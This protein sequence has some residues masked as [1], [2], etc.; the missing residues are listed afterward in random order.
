MDKLDWS[1]I[2]AFLAVA[3][4]GSLSA[5]ARQLGTSQPTLGR[6]IK[7]L[8][9]DLNADLFHRQPRGLVL[10]ETGAKLMEPARA[11]AEAM[12]RLTMT[13]AGQQSDMTG[14]VRITAS[15]VMS[16]NYLPAIISDLRTAEPAIA[17]DL[18]PSDDTRNLTFREADI[19][20]RMY[21]PSQLDLVTQYLGEIEL[22]LF[23][24]A[25]YLAR[26]GMPTLDNLMDHD[27]VGYDTD[28]R[29][30]DGFSAAGFPVTRD[31]FKVR[32][33]DPLTYWSL[34]RAGCGVGFHQV[35]LGSDDPAIRRIDLGFDLPT[36][37]MWLTAHEVMRQTPRIRRV[38]D[39]LRDGL[40]PL[41]S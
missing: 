20:L 36:L 10:T 29:I 28:M 6:Q 33:D 7:T 41:A 31:F 30:I 34:I 19:A 17:I 24:S 3:D 16:A 2:R 11:M 26:R 15:I 22:G 27:F 25:D 8:E 39:A 35:A 1:L 5:A 4:T 9:A 37:P 38:W 14:T 21:R 13:A 18:V 12:Q 40:T 23:A 32:C